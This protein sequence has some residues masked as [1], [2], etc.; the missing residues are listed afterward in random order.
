MRTINIVQLIFIFYI[1]LAFSFGQND[2][3][4]SF[5]TSYKNVRDAT[6]DI[7]YQAYEPKIIK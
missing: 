4:E 7:D 2:K 3:L 5:S 6:E 1:K